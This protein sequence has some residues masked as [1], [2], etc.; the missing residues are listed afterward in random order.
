MLAFSIHIGVAM[1]LML[2]GNVHAMSITL[3]DSLTGNAV[4]MEFDFTNSS[5]VEIGQ[6]CEDAIVSQMQDFALNAVD[7]EH[8]IVQYILLAC[9]SATNAQ[10]V[11]FDPSEYVRRL[12]PQVKGNELTQLFDRHLTDKGSHCHNFGQFYHEHLRKFQAMKPG[13]LNYLELGSLEGASLRA[14]REYFPHAGR[15]VGVDISPRVWFADEGANIHCEVGSQTDSE[16]LTGVNARLGPFDIMIDD[17]GHQLEPTLRSFEILFPLLRDGG[18]YIIED[19]HIVGAG[20]Y[21]Y[22]SALSKRVFMMSRKSQTHGGDNCCDPWKVF[23]VRAPDEVG[24][25][26]DSSVR[27]VI[28]VPGAIIVKKE[29]KEHWRRNPGA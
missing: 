28:L 6:H 12:Y 20:I 1:M 14:F 26:I 7:D 23:G 18:V 17:A 4:L 8:R 16:F 21:D 29:V 22:F 2:L 11:H 10:G 9:V 19:T 24:Y 3:H 27:E 25:S 13:V 15:L 5:S